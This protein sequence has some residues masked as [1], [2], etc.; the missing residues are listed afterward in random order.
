MYKNKEV[1]VILSEDANGVYEEL[2]EIVYEE[3]KK[4]S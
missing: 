3:K 1:K 2:N 4:R